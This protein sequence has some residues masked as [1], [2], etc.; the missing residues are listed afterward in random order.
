MVQLSHLY[1]TT[2]KNHSLDYRDLCRE[3]ALLFID[4]F[5]SLLFINN[6]VQV[7]QSFPSKEEG[8][9][10]IMTAVTIHSVFGAQEN[11]TCHYF[12]FFPFYW[13]RDMGQD[14]TIL[15]SLMLSFKPAFSFCFSPLSESLWFLFTVC[16]QSGVV[17]ISEVVDISPGNLDSIS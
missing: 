14:A 12:H 13:P 2:G 9:F 6:T 5:I 16:H 4:L 8:S 15:V 10:S 3:C 17:W 7:C 1:M 11:K